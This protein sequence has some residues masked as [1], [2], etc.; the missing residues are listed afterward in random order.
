MQSF[1]RLALQILSLLILVILLLPIDLCAA[2]NAGYRM[3]VQHTVDRLQQWY[4]PD[5]G[6]W[7]TTGW[8][9]SA[10]ALTAI[11]DYSRA[12]KTHQYD[13]VLAH[14]FKQHKFAGFLNDYYDDE[15]WWALAWVD[16][17][18][19]TNNA[20]YLQMADSIFD[21]MVGGWDGTCGGGIWWSKERKYK[22]AI[23][24]ELFLDVAAHLSNRTP[25][26]KLKAKYLDWADRE[27]QWFA[28]SSM[29]APDHEIND[30]LTSTCQN[31]QKTVW[32]Y[33]QGVILGGLA[34]LSRQP[35]RKKLLSTAQLIADAAILHLADRDGILH[36]PCEPEC[37]EDSTQ[38]KGIFVRNLAILQERKHARRYLRFFSSNAGSLVTKAKNID[39]SFG[40][41]WSGPPAPADASTQS[42]ALD[43]LTAALATH[44]PVHAF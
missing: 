2:D 22:N 36:D 43:A 7:A 32:S 3:Q 6:L 24:N 41:V 16:A 13:S 29:I 9:N 5:T 25:D 4:K 8:W 44:A 40:V 15:G 18:D 37:S 20:E 17:Y 21:D 19:L 35:H 39:Q 30:G 27:W 26:L 23:A 12:T 14:S 42:A 38:F 1:R 31:N 34:E 11:I 33:N 28:S 10:N